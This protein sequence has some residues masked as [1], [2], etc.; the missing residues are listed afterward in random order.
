MGSPTTNEISS[1]SSAEN[2]L[3]W[4]L[5]LIK[6]AEKRILLDPVVLSSDSVD[7]NKLD[8]AQFTRVTAFGEFQHDKEILLGPRTFHADP[9]AEPSGGGLFGGPMNIGYYVYT[10]FKL[11]DGNCIL[12]NRGWIPRDLR[13][14]TRRKSD[15]GA[16]SI[17]GVVRQGE[18]VG[19]L[20]KWSAPNKP[21]K[22]EWHAIDLAQMAA[23]TGT[24][25]LIVQMISGSPI[26]EKHM[27]NEGQP[28]LPRVHAKLRNNHLEYALTWF[29]LCA[30]TSFLIL[31]RKNPAFRISRR[32]L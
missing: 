28:L 22:N 16:T 13:H 27:A 6:Q 18:S 12:V 3:Q 17:E 20:Q 8:E 26:N 2:R 21:E 7:L 31:Y 19:A 29:G 24:L 4:K 11:A 30:A 14:D 32:Q 25:P 23:H 9:A 15:S 1:G 10:P 5:G